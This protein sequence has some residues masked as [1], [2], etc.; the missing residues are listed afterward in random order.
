MQGQGTPTASGLAELRARR[1]ELEATAAS[2]LYAARA[3]GRETLS[4]LESRQFRDYQDQLG[5][6]DARIEDYAHELQRVGTLPAGLGQGGGGMGSEAFTANWARQTLRSLKAALGGREERAVISGSVDVPVLIEP[7]V[8]ATPFKKRLIDAYGQKRTTPSTAIEYFQQTARTNNAAPVAD[9]A[10]KP[11]IGA[12]R[13]AGHRPMQGR[14][15]TVREPAAQDLDRRDGHH[16]LAHHAA[17][18]CGGR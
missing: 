16:L 5:A 9:L 17:R 11:T 12:H 4:D 1:S 10:Q 8:V 13:D 14:G 6:M 18:R 15:H 2:Y 7:E 3:Q